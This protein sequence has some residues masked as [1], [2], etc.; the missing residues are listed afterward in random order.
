MIKSDSVDVGYID[1][2]KAVGIRFVRIQRSK[3]I[4]INRILL[5]LI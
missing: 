3:F 2:F 4:A 5:I 1:L